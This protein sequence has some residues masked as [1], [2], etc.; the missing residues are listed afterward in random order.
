MYTAS[1]LF[2]IVAQSTSV[3]PTAVWN[4]TFNVI[5]GITSLTGSSATT[6]NGPHDVSFG[7]NNTLYVADYYNNRIQK[8][9]GGSPTAT[10]VI[11]LS[12]YYPSSVYVD[13]NN[14]LYVLD[15]QNY[16]VLK[17]VNGVVTTIAG[18]HG[19]GSTLDK[20]GTS[21]GMYI[22]ANSNIYVSEFS[23]HRVTLWTA[24]NANSSQVVCFYDSLYFL[25]RHFYFRWL[26]AMVKV[27]HQI[28]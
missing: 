11:N 26:G 2:V 7:P 23:N 20:I 19:S 28:S 9:V 14:I 24:G 15:N 6:F 12:L 18:G 22:D 1:V 17:W 5:A 25:Y 10:T 21:Y 27:V 13:N 4:N 3:C 16:R 8:F